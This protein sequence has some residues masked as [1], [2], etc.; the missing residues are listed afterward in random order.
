MMCIVAPT[1]LGI[2]CCIVVWE[3]AEDLGFVVHIKSANENP[4]RTL[5]GL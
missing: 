3:A 4:E 1:E 2:V 5:L